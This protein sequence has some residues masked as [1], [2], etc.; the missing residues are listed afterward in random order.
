LNYVPSF[1]SLL[2]DSGAFSEHNSGVRVD[3]GEYKEWVAQFPHAAAWAGLDDISG[4]WKRSLANYKHGGFP[5]FHSTDP[6]ELLDDLIP[7]AREGQKW[8]GV[9][10]LPPRPIELADWLAETLERIPDDLHVH[11]W[12]LGK[13]SGPRFARIDSKDSTNWF[14]DSFK[15][16][17]Q[18]ST[19]HLTPAECLEIIVKKYQRFGIG[20]ADVTLWA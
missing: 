15:L 14:R 4:D 12:A 20:Q 2:L 16:M 19:A 6:K 5:T 13:F 3:I 8:I 18:K 1:S 17:T 9:G 10:M 7:L 11:G